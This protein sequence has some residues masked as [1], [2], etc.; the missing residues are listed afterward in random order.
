[1][2]P[3]HFMG[4]VM[5]PLEH[6]YAMMDLMGTIV[7]VCFNYSSFSNEFFSQFMLDISLNVMA[8]TAWTVKFFL[9][10]MLLTLTLS[11]TQYD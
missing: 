8:H 5:I 10:F 4:H 3:V 9:N 2:V 7:K 1:M 6:A 11:E